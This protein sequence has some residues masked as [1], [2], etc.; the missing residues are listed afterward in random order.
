VIE[1]LIAAVLL[2]EPF[3]PR[4]AKRDSRNGWPNGGARDGRRYLVTRDHPKALAEPNQGGGEDR[5]CA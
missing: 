1:S 3:L 2:V 4:D 5:K